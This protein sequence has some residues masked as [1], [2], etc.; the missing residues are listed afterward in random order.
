MRIRRKN[1]NRM[2]I[3]VEELQELSFV[4][5]LCIPL[6]TAVV[7]L[8]SRSIAITIAIIIA[9]SPLVFASLIRRKRITTDFWGMFF[10]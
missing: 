6:L 10:F 1:I 9:Y 7:N 4:L 3:N 2:K 8:F 5:Y